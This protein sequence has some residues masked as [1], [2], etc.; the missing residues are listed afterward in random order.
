MD[1][2]DIINVGLAL[3]TIGFG[4]LGW[5]APVY[6]MKT[7]GLRDRGS[8][9]GTSEVR[10]ASGALFVVAGAGALILWTPAAFAMIGF[11]W[12]GARWGA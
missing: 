3:L 9:M 1:F 10:A 6:T 2:I 11:I 7:V 8:T 4:A 12:A 5:L